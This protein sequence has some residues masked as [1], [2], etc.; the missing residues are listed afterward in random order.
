M[1]A[2]TWQPQVVMNSQDSVQEN[3]LRETEAQGGSK[4][5]QH[6]LE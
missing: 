1:C 6:S 5:H 3:Q 2:Q 4:S